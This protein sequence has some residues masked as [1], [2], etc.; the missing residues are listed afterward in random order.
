MSFPLIAAGVE[1]AAS[2][3][4]AY[5]AYQEGQAASQTAYYNAAVAENNAKIAEQMANRE[6]A[7]GVIAA[8]RESMKTGARVGAIKAAQAANGV[9]VNSGSAV[10]VQASERMLGKLE[11]DTVLNNAQLRAYG[12]RVQAQSDRAQAEL[13][14]RGGDQAKTAGKIGAAGDLLSGAASV[15]TKWYES[16]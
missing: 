16:K 1:L 15:A 3:I 7:A 13:Y 8:S 12:Y 9:D 4:K 11:A 6:A 14:R 2:G 10:D 5:G